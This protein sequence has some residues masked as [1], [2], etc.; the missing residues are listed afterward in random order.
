MGLELLPPH[1][2]STWNLVELKLQLEL[3]MHRVTQQVPQSARWRIYIYIYISK[4]FATSA[5][6]LVQGHCF[7]SVVDGLWHWFDC[8]VDRVMRY[9][10]AGESGSRGYQIR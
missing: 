5:T 7:D 9:E 3:S 4:C 10:K 6:V 1:G 8:V 2:D